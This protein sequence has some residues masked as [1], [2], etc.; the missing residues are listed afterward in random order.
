MV[1]RASGFSLLEMV[2]SVSLFG[3]LM[4][5]VFYFLA[6][7][8]R[9]FQFAQNRASVQN[10]VLGVKSSLTADLEQTHFLGVHSLEVKKTVSKRKSSEQVEA[11]RDI[12]TMVALSKWVLNDGTFDPNSGFSYGG[13]PVWDT[14]VVYRPDQVGDATV[15]LERIV[16]HN[17][18]T[19]A[20][21]KALGTPSGF[22][23]FPNLSFD[24]K[25]RPDTA[26]IS[27]LAKNVSHFEVSQDS[28][29]QMLNVKLR[30][31]EDGGDIT[32]AAEENIKETTVIFGIRP[33]NTVPKL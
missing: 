31:L 9:G 5:M 20:S 30:I 26:R 12:L 25:S 6:I 33:R 27:A 14:H 8:N 13:I 32:A 24:A 15:K 7:G 29:R 22:A 18:S 2:I 21:A 28:T 10:Q 11:R 1:K 19:R 4:G 16:L 3:L 23:T 17:N